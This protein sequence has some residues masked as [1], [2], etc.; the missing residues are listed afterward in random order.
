MNHFAF[1]LDIFNFR[2]SEAS[3]LLFLLPFL[4]PF[5]LGIMCYAQDNSIELP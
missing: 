5:Y 3:L 4:L 1:S 2:K